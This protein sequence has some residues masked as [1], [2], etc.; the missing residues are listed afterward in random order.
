MD[1]ELGRDYRSELIIGDLSDHL[2]CLLLCQNASLCNA[3]KVHSEKR[4][5]TA[6]AINK[7][8]KEL[9]QISWHD[10]LQWLNCEQSFEN[11]HSSLRSIIDENAPLK[12]VN[13]KKKSKWGLPWITRGIINSTR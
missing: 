9:Q 7:M 1:L 8:N 13:V 6:K 4:H 11:F 10:R 2:P 12:K 3:S 5:L